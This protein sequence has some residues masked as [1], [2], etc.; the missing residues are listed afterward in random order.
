[1]PFKYHWL[2]V[3]LEEVNVTL[4]PLQKIVGPFALT[5]G[6]AG[7][8]GCAFMLAIVAEETQPLLPFA[9]TE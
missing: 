8:A 4:P 1:M 6:V 3:A 5:V 9:V 2:P 7:V